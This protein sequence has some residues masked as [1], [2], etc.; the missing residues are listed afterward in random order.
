MNNHG[1]S[2][3]VSGTIEKGFTIIGPFAHPVLATEWASTWEEDITWEV[4]PLV[5]RST[6]EILDEPLPQN[7]GTL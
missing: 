2:V 1:M 4:M 5:A 3:V 6:R 7:P